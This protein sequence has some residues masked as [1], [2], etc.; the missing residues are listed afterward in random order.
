MG[1]QDDSEG[2]KSPTSI[3][4]RLQ[5]RRRTAEPRQHVVNFMDV[6]GSQ[7]W[8]LDEDFPRHKRKLLHEA[9]PLLL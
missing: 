5:F 7:T 3:L 1:V 2:G 8:I 9:D 6:G 4:R